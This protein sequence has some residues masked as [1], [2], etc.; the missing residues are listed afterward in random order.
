[1]GQY[2]QPNEQGQFTFTSVDVAANTEKKGI[3]WFRALMSS[4]FF[5]SFQLEL[6]NKKNQEITI[7]RQRNGSKQ[8]R[9]T[10][11]GT[12]RP[13]ERM[14]NTLQASSTSSTVDTEHMLNQYR[15]IHPARNQQLFSIHQLCH[16]VISSIGSLTM[17]HLRFDRLICNQI[18]K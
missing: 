1:M 18:E 11:S 9:S 5:F 12:D 10:C 2:S 6:K 8:V 13:V 4:N 16:S 15:I 7:Q 3:L 14:I 17:Q